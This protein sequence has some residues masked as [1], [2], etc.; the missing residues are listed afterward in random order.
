MS[1]SSSLNGFLDLPARPSKPRESRHHARHGQGSDPVQIEGLLARRRR[2]RRHRQ[3][4]LG[5]VVRHA[6]P[7]REAGALPL[8]RHPRGLRRDPSGDRGGA[9]QARRLSRLAERHGFESV[10]VSDGTIELPRERKLELIDTLAR[11]FRVLWRSA[12]RTPRRSSRP[13]SGS[14]GSAR[15]SAPAPGRS[16]RRH[17]S[18][19]PRASSAAAARCAAA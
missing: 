19:A 9:Q 5:H 10:E 7:A 15:S 11:D 13:T 18:R 2:L 12:R 16:S 17:A 14:S 6:E 1:I 4:R 3:A 8:A